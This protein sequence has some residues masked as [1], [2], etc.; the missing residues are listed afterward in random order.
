MAYLKPF[1]GFCIGF[2]VGADCFFLIFIRMFVSSKSSVLGFV[3]TNC[4]TYSLKLF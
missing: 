3:Q 2:V 4:I 1:I